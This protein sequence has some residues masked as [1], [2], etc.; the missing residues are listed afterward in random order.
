MFVRVTSEDE[1]QLL[2][3]TIKNVCY[4]G[5]GL[6]SLADT[7]LNWTW[8]R[9]RYCEFTTNPLTYLGSWHNAEVMAGHD[10]YS[11]QDFLK[12]IKEQL[13]EIPL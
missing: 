11:V 8:E 2:Y 12:L 5:I 1:R 9:N 10:N 4:N 3:N 13:E 7:I 6:C